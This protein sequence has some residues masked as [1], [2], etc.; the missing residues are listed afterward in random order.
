MDF[1]TDT[2]FQRNK[3]IVASEID[4]ETVMMDKDFEKYFGL[5]AIGTRVWQLLE[6][7][8]TIQQI[9]EQ[10]TTDYDVSLEHC[11]N[12]LKSL[13][14]DLLKNEMVVQT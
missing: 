8:I 12:D 7:P 4:N 6:Q 9:A 11:M 2:I 10:L 14:A 3:D 13:M 1:S 5:Q